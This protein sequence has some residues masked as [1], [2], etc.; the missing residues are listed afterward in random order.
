MTKIEMNRRA[1]RAW[2]GPEKVRFAA[3]QRRQ[4]EDLFATWRV[5][6]VWC[7]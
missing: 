1:D 7:S 5:C 3:F 6:S 2:A 4:A